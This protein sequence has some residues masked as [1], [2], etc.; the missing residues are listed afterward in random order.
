M[1]RKTKVAVIAELKARGIEFDENMKYEDL[2]KLLKNAA[3]VIDAAAE[4]LPVP[5]PELDIIGNP[6]PVEAVELEE[7]EKPVLGTIS[8][9]LIE[10]AKKIGFT[11][12]Q[13]ATYNDAEKLEAACDLLKPQATPQPPPKKRQIFRP[14]KDKPKGERVK[15]DLTTEISVKRAQAVRRSD[16][17]NMILGDFLR[18]KKIRP[19]NVLKVIITRDYVPDKKDILTSKIVVI[20]LK[21]D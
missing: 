16:Y 7:P 11:D 15:V 19:E 9:E 4:E 3:P 6:I 21:K 13:I 17:D 8:D 2:W 20:Y 5:E 14:F 10:R 12:E 18:K 1:A